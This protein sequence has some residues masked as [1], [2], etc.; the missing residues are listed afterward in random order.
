MKIGE[1][2]NPHMAQFSEAV[3]KNVLQMLKLS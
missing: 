1:N 3:M 2:L